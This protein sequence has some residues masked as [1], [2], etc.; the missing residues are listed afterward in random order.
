M[1]KARQNGPVDYQAM[2]N[3]L[4]H[5]FTMCKYV[6]VCVCVCRINVDQCKN[7]Q[8]A[9]FLYFILSKPGGLSL[10]EQIPN[11]RQTRNE[12]GA[13]DD[14][15]LIFS[16]LHACYSNWRKI[17]LKNMLSTS[18]QR[19]TRR[20]WWWMYVWMNELQAQSSRE[21]DVP[22]TERGTTVDDV[23]MLFMLQAD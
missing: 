10:G 12:G 16:V 6:C 3:S 9:L 8:T 20:C 5:N 14:H 11:W 17:A 15:L 2:S 21:C 7:T 19:W 1:K 13:C 22:N 4:Q 18:L 23:L